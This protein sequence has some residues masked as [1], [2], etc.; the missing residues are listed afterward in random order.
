MKKNDEKRIETMAMN[1]W[2]KIYHNTSDDVIA[3]AQTNRNHLGRDML[4]VRSAVSDSVLALSVR[5]HD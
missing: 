4:R 5:D 3:F 1:V 2:W